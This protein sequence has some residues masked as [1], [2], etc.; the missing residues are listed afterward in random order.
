MIP[1]FYKGMVTKQ[2]IRKV[3]NDESKVFE[4]KYDMYTCGR[5]RCKLCH[6]TKY[7]NI[8]KTKNKKNNFNYY[9]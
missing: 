9:F 7:T 5:T 6:P 8:G 4:Y 2:T 3:Y 1:K